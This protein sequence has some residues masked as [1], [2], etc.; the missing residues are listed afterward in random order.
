[1]SHDQ[2]APIVVEIAKAFISLL[3]DTEIKWQKAYLRFSTRKTMSETKGSYVIDGKVE[4]I[5]TLKNKVFFHSM[6]DRG[7]R[8]F[9]ALGKSEGVFL[10][11][12]D[13]S[14]KYEFKFEHEDLDR[15]KISKIGEGTGIPEGIE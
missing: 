10:L 12:V 2:A 4:L 1:M 15:W 13:A 9:S 3:R 14:L 8:L 6:P 7:R 5:D 11:I